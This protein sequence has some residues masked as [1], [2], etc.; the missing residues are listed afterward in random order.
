MAYSIVFFT[1]T[2][3]H[4]ILFVNIYYK[5]IW[6]ITVRIILGSSYEKAAFPTTLLYKFR[7]WIDFLH[8]GIVEMSI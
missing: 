5:K 6:G 3:C 7:I 2:I 4:I 1:H 8:S